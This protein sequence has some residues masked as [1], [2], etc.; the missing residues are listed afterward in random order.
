MVL[1]YIIVYITQ[2]RHL[3]LIET[4]YINQSLMLWIQAQ[5]DLILNGFRF[6][7]FQIL[8]NSD[9]S[10]FRCEWIQMRADSNDNKLGCGCDRKRMW[11]RAY[12]EMS[13]CGY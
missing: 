11:I 5:M 6:E 4:Q 2:L 13:G 12:A 3:T 7:R 9:T 8:A 10:R 1:L